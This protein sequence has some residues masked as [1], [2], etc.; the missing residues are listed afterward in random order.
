[1]NIQWEMSG[2]DVHMNDDIGRRLKSLFGILTT[3]TGVD[4]ADPPEH[5]ATMEEQGHPVEGDIA[6]FSRPY[7]E[8][9]SSLDPLMSF[10]RAG[11]VDPLYI[12]E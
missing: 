12:D 5:Q 11:S 1:M 7:R 10:P 6:T 9:Q 8:R 4:S 3:M 2:L